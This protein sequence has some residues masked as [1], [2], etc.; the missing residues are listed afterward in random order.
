[1]LFDCR[2]QLWTLGNRPI[3]HDYRETNKVANRLAKEGTKLMT[4]NASFC[5]K[6]S[7]VFVFKE[8]QVDIDRTYFVR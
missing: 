6:V 2:E 1:M 8:L 4:P 7:P 3:Q 5:W